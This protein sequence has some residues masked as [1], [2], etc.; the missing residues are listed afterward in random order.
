MCNIFATRVCSERARI[1]VQ[2]AVIFTEGICTIVLSIIDYTATLF[3]LQ[4]LFIVQWNERIDV[5]LKLDEE[6]LGETHSSA[7]FSVF[8][9]VNLGK[10]GN[11]WSENPMSQLNLEPLPSSA[12]ALSN[13]QKLNVTYVSEVILKYDV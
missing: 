2:I 4:V 1:Q 12:V 10:S 8:T 7:Y 9:W 5:C 11:S 3:Q 13:R 6:E